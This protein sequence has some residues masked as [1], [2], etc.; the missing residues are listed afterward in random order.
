M[1][2]ITDSFDDKTVS[3]LK[4]GGVAVVRTDTLYGI[5]ARADNQAAVDRVYAIKE[6]TPTKSPIVLISSPSQL[7]D[8]YDQPTLE[9]LHELWPDKV[10]VILPSS[11]APAWLTRGNA[12]V[13][14]RL[15]DN[16][17]L[18]ELVG[19]TGPLIAPS[20][21]PE[22]DPPAMTIAQARGYFG[23]SVDVYVDGGTVTDNSP[24]K[25]YRLTDEGME[26]LR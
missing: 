5:V 3:I 18:R 13:A 17:P 23:D 11:A 21:N 20:A 7:F 15:P 9:R 8:T 1:T 22:G 19:A 2:Y 14:Y 4:D 6:R 12:S 25:L 16:T 10:S 24:S 26:R